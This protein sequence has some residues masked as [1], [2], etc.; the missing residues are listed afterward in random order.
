MR[1]WIIFAILTLA[2]SIPAYADP[3]TKPSKPPATDTQAPSMTVSKA[4]ELLAALRN[5]DG[6]TVIVKQNGQETTV[7]QTCDGGSG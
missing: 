3:A 7:M 2:L 1:S 6:H 4:L 5:L